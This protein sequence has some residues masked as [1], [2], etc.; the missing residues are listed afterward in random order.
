MRGAGL[1]GL[2]VGLSAVAHWL[3][4]GHLPP[5]GML[6]GLSLLLLPAGVW[7]AGR[8]LSPVAAGAFLAVGQAGLHAAF[9]VLMTCP[10]PGPDL[11]TITLPGHA[12]HGSGPMVMHCAG[13]SA[14]TGHAGGASMFAFHAVA[15]LATVLIVGGAQRLAGWLADGLTARL[16]PAPRPLVVA[17]ART[18]A[19]W[20]PGVVT[21]AAHLRA[22]ATR[23]GPPRPLAGLGT[24]LA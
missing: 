13:T 23:R 16:A 15:T 4:G 18:A 5:T 10:A 12:G 22:K 14:P 2:V 11:T 1:V 20:R 24:A 9:R 17:R 3:G 21:G 8:R 7:T 19:P 6:A